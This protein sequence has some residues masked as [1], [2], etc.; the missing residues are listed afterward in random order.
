ME[1]LQIPDIEDGV[2]MSR[3]DANTMEYPPYH[4]TEF[5]TQIRTRTLC[6]KGRKQRKVDGKFEISNVSACVETPDS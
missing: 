2:K 3:V 1:P 5:Y 4:V 6:L